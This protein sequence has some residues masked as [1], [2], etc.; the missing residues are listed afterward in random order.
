MKDSCFVNLFYVHSTK[1]LVDLQDINNRIVKLLN[2]IKLTLLKCEVFSMTG[3]VLFAH[4]RD[5]KRREAGG[6]QTR[7]EGACLKECRRLK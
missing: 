6:E 2:K 7:R 5:S 3:M 1:K 4:L